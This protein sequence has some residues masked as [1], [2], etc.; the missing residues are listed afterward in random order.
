[1]NDTITGADPSAGFEPFACAYVE[2]Y[3][4]DGRVKIENRELQAAVHFDEKRA[5]R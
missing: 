4:S 3:H 2:F 5:F 1:L